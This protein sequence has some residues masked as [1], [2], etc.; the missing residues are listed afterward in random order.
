MS[1][2]IYLLREG[3]DWHVILPEDRMDIGHV[4]W[5]EQTT[6]YLISRR[7]MIPR[8]KLTNLPY[9]VRRAR[10]VGNVVYYGEYPD[11]AL[12]EAIRQATGNPELT[13]CYDDHERRLKADVRELRKLIRRYSP[14][15]EVQLP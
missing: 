8:R 15:L 11:P 13:F 2:P 12:L 14:A 7:Y 1:F 6:S 4:D 3:A 5:W 9:C 10:I